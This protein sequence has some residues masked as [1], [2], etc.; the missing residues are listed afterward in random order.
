MTNRS[1][2]LTLEVANLEVPVLDA[3]ILSLPVNPLCDEEC[4]G[5]CPDCGEKWESLP[6]D[7]AHDVVDARWAG[8][9]DLDLGSSGQ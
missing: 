9:S 4:L 5:L 7:H 6:E 3:I 1:N 8:L 2:S